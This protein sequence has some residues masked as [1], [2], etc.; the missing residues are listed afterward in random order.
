MIYQY[1]TR[2]FFRIGKPFTG[3]SISE[4]VEENSLEDYELHT[5]KSVEGQHSSVFVLEFRR[6]VVAE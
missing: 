1:E 4:L 6:Q 3:R 5:H 2:E